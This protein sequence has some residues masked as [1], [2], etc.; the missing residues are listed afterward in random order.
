MYSDRSFFSIIANDLGSL[1]YYG[2]FRFGHNNLM[3]CDDAIWWRGLEPGQY[4]VWANECR[5]LVARLDT[6]DPDG[7]ILVFPGV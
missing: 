6:S 4:A 3:C 7:F 1:K 5:G 2:E